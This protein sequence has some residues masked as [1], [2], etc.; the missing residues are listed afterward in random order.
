VNARLSILVAALVPALTW[1][2][3]CTLEQRSLIRSVGRI[4]QVRNVRGTV[5]SLRDRTRKCT[6][7]FQGL[8][9]GVW[10]SGFGE[11]TWSTDMPDEVAC[12]NAFE[13]G[14]A[15]LIELTGNQR[16]TDER[17]LNCLEGSAS[18]MTLRVGDTL[19]EN[20]WTPHPQRIG[21]FWYQGAECRW[22][23]ETS[24]SG[25]DLYQWQGIVCQ[26]R[27]GEWVVVDKF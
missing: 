7:Q 8:V 20:A 22:F 21:S 11:Y 18:A 3:D 10:S 2:N 24:L 6:M 1:A 27:A 17:Y 13:R 4:D 15:A 12:N 16:I 23:I 5:V 26:I 25:R 9:N 19:R 14:K